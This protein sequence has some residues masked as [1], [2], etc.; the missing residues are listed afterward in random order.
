VNACTTTSPIGSG[1]K[2][3]QEMLVEFASGTRQEFDLST[4]ERINIAAQHI[5]HVREPIAAIDQ[6]IKALESRRS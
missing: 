4:G 2:S 6:H 5:T 3:L 1:K